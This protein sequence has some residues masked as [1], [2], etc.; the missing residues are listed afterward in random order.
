[1]ALV[2]VD[3]QLLREE[4]VKAGLA[5]VYNY[6]CSEPICKSWKNYQ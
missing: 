1:V 2:A 3:R 6:Y 4:L 5:W